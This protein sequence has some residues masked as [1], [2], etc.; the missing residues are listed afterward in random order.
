MVLARAAPPAYA[1]P[2]SDSKVDAAPGTERPATLSVEGTCPDGDAIWTDVRT[3]VP[4]GD[5]SHVTTAKID[6]TDLGESYR[7]R[8][9]GQEGERLRVYRDLGR[10]CDHR[11]RFA[12]VFIV[13]T[14]LPPDIL[15]DIR[16]DASPP[17]PPPPITPKPAAAVRPPPLPAPPPSKRLRLDVSVMVDVAP[18]ISGGPSAA[19]LGGEL[20]FSWGARA[21][22]PTLGAGLEPRTSFQVGG[23]GVD[24]FRAPF[25]VGASLVKALDRMTL[26]GDLGLA[27]VL[28]R[29]SGT[30]TFDPQS[31]T[32]LDLGARL[33]VALRIGRPSATVAPVVGV[34]ALLLPKPYELTH[35]PQGALGRLPALWIGATAGISFSP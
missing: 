4:A 21:V 12:A 29:V 28:F 7:V 17:P 14:L 6:V 32:R 22:A 31:G 26:T 35:T 25:D 13:L 18:P 16:P 23:L 3:I 1:A 9:V 8:I 11:A 15:L 24:E 27:G 20:R 30:D 2:E 33:A 10:D 34:H 19:A 5:L